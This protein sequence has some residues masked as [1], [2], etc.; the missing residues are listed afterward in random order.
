MGSDVVYFGCPVADLYQ[1][2]KE[3]LAK[4]GIGLIVIPV[5]KNYAELFASKIE[6]NVF[7]LEIEKLEK[8]Q[9]F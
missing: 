2:F 3:R 7:D 9:Y 5:R 8:E 6:E 1:V 4:G